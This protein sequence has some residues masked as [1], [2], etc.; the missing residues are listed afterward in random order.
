MRH[1]MRHCGT[2]RDSYTVWG[3]RLSTASTLGKGTVFALSILGLMAFLLTHVS[4]VTMRPPQLRTIS[5]FL[6]TCLEGGPSLC[7]QILPIALCYTTSTQ[8]SCY[9]SS[10]TSSPH[11]QKIFRRK[12]LLLIRKGK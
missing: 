9:H 3:C 7:S 6:S 8:L 11:L 4:K 12:F 5:A 10:D 2:G 1:V